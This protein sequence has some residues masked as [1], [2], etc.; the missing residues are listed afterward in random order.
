M[1]QLLRL[2]CA[3]TRRRALSVEAGDQGEAGDAQETLSCGTCRFRRRSSSVIDGM[4]VAGVSVR[5][6]EDVAEALWGTRG[7]SGTVSRLNQ[8][9]YRHIGTWRS[10]AMEARL[11]AVR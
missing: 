10:R 11:T 2:Q 3:N 8:K 9:S 5:R 4:Y 1:S 7:S 6:V